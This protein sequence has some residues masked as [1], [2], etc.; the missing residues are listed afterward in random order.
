[1]SAIRKFKPLEFLVQRRE[2]PHQRLALR[3]HALN[4]HK[5]RPVPLFGV[6]GCLDAVAND[7]HD[8][9]TVLFEAAPKQN[10]SACRASSVSCASRSL[11]WV[12]ARFMAIASRSVNGLVELDARGLGALLLA[13]VGGGARR[14]LAA[15][16][17]RK[18]FGG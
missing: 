11:D 9:A 10:G 8:I 6:L 12:P 3:I 15:K 5:V 13:L 14:E 17:R 18:I 7:S 16:R 2:L 4:P 1:M